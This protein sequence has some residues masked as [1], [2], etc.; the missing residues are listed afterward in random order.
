MSTRDYRSSLLLP[1]TS[2]P[3]R[4]GLPH[5]EPTSRTRWDRLE[6]LRDPSLD[7]ATWVLHDGPPYAN[8]PLHL[9]H[10][11]NKC[12]KDFVARHR[13]M[14]GHDVH[15]RFGWDCHGLPVERRVLDQH[16]EL[17]DA[18]PAS[19]REACHRWATAW[20]EHQARQ[21]WRMLPR[22]GTEPYRTLDPAYEAGVLEVVAELVEQGLLER[23]LRP[24]R[25]SLGNRTAL[26]EAEL[27]FAVR[28]D[29]SVW[30][31]YRA[32][33]DGD[34][35]A[36]FGV[37]CEPVVFTAW[38]T[39]PWTLP[40]NLALAVDPAADYALVAGGAW[41]RVV[42]VAAVEALA[43]AVGHPLSVLATAPGSALLDLRYAP[44]LTAHHPDGAFRVVSGS[45]VDAS[46]GSGV[47]HTA[48]GHGPDDYRVGRAEGL[49]T[50]SVLGADG[51]LGEPVPPELSGLTPEA[52]NHRVLE[53]LR[54]DGGL[55]A[56]GTVDHTVAVDWR[57]NSR[58]VFRA[59][60]QWFVAL[61]RPTR[62][63]PTLR[64]LA[65]SALDD[66]Q[67]H[68]ASSR[69]RLEAMLRSRPDWC[70]SRQR[71]WGLP[72]P[73]FYD[74]SGAPV[75]TRDSVLAV[76]RTVRREGSAAWLR[77]SP[78]E[79]LESWD[80]DASA[81]TAGSDV[82]DVWVESG[83][84]WHA[85]LA[86][87]P[88]DVVVEGS[89]QHRGWFQSSL[90]LAA[91]CTG[92]APFRAVVTHGFVVEERTKV[93]KSAGNARDLDHLVET[94]GADVLRWWVATQRVSC[95]AP[96]S[97]A[98]L[99]QAAR[100]YRKLR[101]TL[102]YALGNLS[103]RPPRPPAR[104]GP[105]SPEAWLLGE[106]AETVRT[107]RTSFTELAFADAARALH[108][109]CT[110][111]SAR[112]LAM[113]KDRLYCDA[114]DSARRRRAQDALFTCVDAVS[115]LLAPLVPHLAD[116]VWRHLHGL[117]D[118]PAATVHTQPLPA[119]AP[120][121]VHPG[122]RCADALK[123]VVDQRL[124]AVRAAGQLT[125]S[126][127]TGLVVPDPE[128]ALSH[129]ASRDLADWFG[130]SDVTLA[131][132]AADVRVVDRRHVPRCERSRR[133]SADVRQRPSGAWLSDRD[134]RV[135]GDG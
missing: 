111:L 126:Q 58:V 41:L 31:D 24:V 12:L 73:V 78:A 99:D 98:A 135:V 37:A 47:V 93:G 117:E 63:G 118:D 113:A 62:H 125:D 128:G 55:A 68:P 79:L 57:G 122:W 16:P 94:Y 87:R 60:P 1:R 90:L 39:A 109:F 18:G 130:V 112:Y 8:G 7:A 59:T 85:V 10:L 121:E 131:G 42:A 133:R 88:A 29:P 15:V 95:D 46:S 5:R 91:A 89:D 71:A 124:E 51:R 132:S 43:Q 25:W 6:A 114:A 4:A 119:P 20:Q 11:L 129:L 83:A 101:D 19:V 61:D 74:A 86:G 35:C 3:P 21:L 80:G 75:L 9:G 32:L 107:V 105:T 92:R 81:L 45:H 22:R 77:R 48:P 14:E 53:L 38:T 40:A 28:N 72:L 76:A 67:F 36:R 97:S 54:R 120:P 110:G 108:Q 96:L 70:V 49:P 103:D 33:D 44:R 30:V 17:V 34:V 104:P 123:R 115:R 23:A 2:M 56:Q 50:T 27:G 100:Q 106:L 116:E 52:A 69:R 127:D 64:E 65:L 66:V 134:A 102:R 13:T 26:A 82:L 84:S